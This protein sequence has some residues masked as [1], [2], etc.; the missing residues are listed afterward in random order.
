MLIARQVSNSKY[1]V[2]IMFRMLNLLFWQC[3]QYFFR[4]IVCLF[5]DRNKNLLLKRK[6]LHKPCN[7]KIVKQ[8]ILFKFKSYFDK[9]T[10]LM[11]LYKCV[12]CDQFCFSDN[13]Q[14]TVNIEL[15]NIFRYM[16]K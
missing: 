5:L 11:Y 16:N 15:F 10:L 14:S 2:H 13:L 6:R 9:M 12:R 7:V 3:E 4:S 8:Y 1:V